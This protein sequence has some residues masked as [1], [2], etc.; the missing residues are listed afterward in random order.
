VTAESSVRCRDT[1]R[2]PPCQ[3]LPCTIKV[4]GRRLLSAPVLLAA[5]R[6]RDPRNSLASSE[7]PGIVEG[8]CSI[9]CTKHSETAARPSYVRRR[10]SGTTR[11]GTELRMVSPVP[12]NFASL[13]QRGKAGEDLVN[14]GLVA[15][16][17][18]VAANGALGVNPCGCGK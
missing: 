8:A 3:A 9:P 10:E 14:M 1:I 5:A 13:V 15:Y 6:G 2:N 4:C 11:A 17:A 18:A 7:G 12:R 16:G